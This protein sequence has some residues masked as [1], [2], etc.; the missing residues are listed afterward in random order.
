MPSAGACS[1]VAVAEV[2]GPA[3]ALALVEGLDLDTYYLSHAVRADLLRRL[4]RRSEASAAYEAAIELADNAAERAFLRR[5][6]SAL[7]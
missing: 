2:S 3:P 5:A 6:R 7:G 4:D 1:S